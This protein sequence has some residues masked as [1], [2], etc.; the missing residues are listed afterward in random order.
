MG[1]KGRGGRGIGGWPSRGAF[2]F[3]PTWRRPWLYG[4]G[5]GY[6]YGRGFGYRYWGTQFYHRAYPRRS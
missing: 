2:S 1:W 5:F 6:G 4:Y 3:L